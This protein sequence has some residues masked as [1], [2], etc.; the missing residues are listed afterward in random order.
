MWNIRKP[1]WFPNRCVSHCLVQSQP[2][3]NDDER[4]VEDFSPGIRRNKAPPDF[5]QLERLIS[6]HHSRLQDFAEASSSLFEE[7][8]AS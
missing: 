3:A 1:D 5:L 4:R 7:N 2:V 8:P 6:T